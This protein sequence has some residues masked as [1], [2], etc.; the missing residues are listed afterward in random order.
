MT[1]Q[2]NPLRIVWFELLG[3]I[4][5]VDFLHCFIPCLV[6]ILICCIRESS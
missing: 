4:I 2:L 1:S 5:M 6:I 3:K